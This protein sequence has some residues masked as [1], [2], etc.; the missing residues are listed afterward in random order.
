M[1]AGDKDR[2]I[3]R[4]LARK[5][6][7]FA[8]LPIHRQK[9]AQ[10]RRHNALKPGRPMVLN[11]PEGVWGEFVPGDALQCADPLCRSI[12]HGLRCRIYRWEHLRDDSPED[13]V[14]VSSLW[15]HITGW[16]VEEQPTLPDGKVFGAK[17]YNTVI[18]TE[19]D[20]DM[21]KPRTATV[22]W[23]GSE[24]QYQQIA[25]LIGD[26]LRVEKRGQSGFGFAP[27]DSFIRWRGIEQTL[28]DLYDRPQWVHQ[29]MDRM[30]RGELD[31]LDQLQAA[32][33]L[34]LNNGANGVGS[35]G[36]GATDELPTK[37]FDGVHVRAR[38]MWGHATTQIFSEVSPAMHDEF[39][40]TYERRYLDRFGLNCYGCCEPL[41]KKTHLLR[42]L[43]R[44][45]RVSM[46]PWIEPAE[47]AAGMGRDYVFSYKPN[48]AYLAAD[49]FDLDLCR[50]ELINVLEKAQGCIIE[51]VLKDTHTARGQ[52]ER[53]WQWTEMA[54]RLADQYA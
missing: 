24:R 18:K 36:I 53:Y 14:Y 30:T 12:E 29:V 7:A 10:W 34:S 20:I 42:K 11:W 19:A 9:L 51:F 23:E 38:D 6:A 41:H 26:I 28:L 17:H 40:I 4:D 32:G 21:I 44:L 48:P 37:D 43:P 27:M 47:A 22:D 5:V 15:I 45:R 3:V 8:S 16:G 35:G 33:A 49:T 39:A 50:K 54:M 25:D 1:A 52:P 2:K 31:L 13:P 46:S